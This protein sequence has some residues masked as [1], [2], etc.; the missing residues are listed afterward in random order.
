MFLL[1]HH[2]LRTATLG[3]FC[4]FQDILRNASNQELLLQK[5]EYVRVLEEKLLKLTPGEDASKQV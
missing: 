2:T 5:Q 4:R 3:W 1:V